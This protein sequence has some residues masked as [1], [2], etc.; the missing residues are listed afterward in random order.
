MWPQNTAV[1]PRMSKEGVVPQP[2]NASHLKSECP[3]HEFPFRTSIIPVPYTLGHKIH[4]WQL[5]TSRRTIRLGGMT[6]YNPRISTEAN[7]EQ[8]LFSRWMG[9]ADSHIVWLELTPSMPLW[10]GLVGF[11]SSVK[12]LTSLRITSQKK[13]VI[14]IHNYSR[15]TYT[16]TTPPHNET[17]IMLPMG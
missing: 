2:V 8:L 13:N 7:Q 16:Y 15:S 12:S 9:T 14:W 1:A 6:D 3:K 10:V 17:T 5:S 11:T 4:S